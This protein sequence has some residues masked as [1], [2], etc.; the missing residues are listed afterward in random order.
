MQ[1]L[2]TNQ[3]ECD[4][5]KSRKVKSYIDIVNPDY[6]INAA[7]IEVNSNV[8]PTKK[9]LDSNLKISNNILKACKDKKN[10][11][12]IIFFGSGLE[13]GD[14]DTPIDESHH[15]NPKNY[16][17]K[18]KAIQSQTSLNL[19]NEFDLPLILIRPFNLYGPHDNK[20][21]FFYVISSILQKKAF[22]ITKGEQIRDILYI[23]DLCVLVEK[24]LFDNTI[25]S[26]EVINAGFGKGILLRDIIDS[27][28]KITKYEGEITFRNYRDN[29]YFS[30]VAD[31][32][33]A[34]KLVGWEPITPIELGLQKT[35]AWVTAI[36]H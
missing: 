24:A 29:E 7:Y 18:T 10:L 15:L 23:E 3:S 8:K 6:I 19:A 2:F 16:Y 1:M 13:Y 26:G 20:S 36:L 4:L 30:Q 21:V 35:I 17:A 28:F 25:S 5:L 22:S 12:K 32:Q 9:Y 27:I 34:K 14:S 31:I 33:K 11:Q